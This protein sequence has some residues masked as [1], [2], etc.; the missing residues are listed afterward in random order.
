MDYFSELLESYTKLKKRTFK[1]VYL[2]E[3]EEAQADEER[4]QQII[5]QILAAAA[6]E[7]PSPGTGEPSPGLPKD[8]NGAQEAGSVLTGQTGQTVAVWRKG[9][10]PDGPIIGRLIDGNEVGQL[11]DA[12]G[13][14]ALGRPAGGAVWKALT[15][16][17]VDQVNRT[18]TTELVQKQQGE[19]GYLFTSPE[20]GFPNAG[21]LT[22]LL[23]DNLLALE[24]ICA[25]QRFENPDLSAI[26]GGEEK[27][28]GLIGGNVT[29][30]LE[31][32]LANAFAVSASPKGLV[33]VEPADLA[34][35]IEGALEAHKRLLTVIA[36]NETITPRLC[37]TINQY[38]GRAKN[39]RLVLYV[40]HTGKTRGIAISQT[41]LQKGVLDFLDH[42]GCGVQKHKYA[43][44]KGSL[45]N[46]QGRVNET[47]LG[48]ATAIASE[49]ASLMA[50]GRAWTP[51]PGPGVGTIP[52]EITQILQYYLQDIAADLE[53]IDQLAG[54][55]P[56]S[57]V[58]IS[59][60]SLELA[61]EI[62]E[63]Q[64]EFGTTDGR[65]KYLKLLLAKNFD[66]LSQINADG[67]S[68]IGA[69]QKLGVKSDSIF[70]FKVDP[71]DFDEALGRAS[72]AAAALKLDPSTAP[73]TKTAQ[74]LVDNVRDNKS[75]VVLLR[76]LDRMLG[77]G[78]KGDEEII[79]VNAAQKLSKDP[80]TKQG[81]LSVVRSAQAWIP[82]GQP[83]AFTGKG[84][85][86]TDPTAYWDRLHKFTGLDQTRIANAGSLVSDIHSNL[87]N[88]SRIS[89]K[90]AGPNAASTAAGYNPF[91]DG[92]GH[93]SVMTSQ[94]IATD[95]QALLQMSFPAG[96]MPTLLQNT[97]REY[98]PQGQQQQID[99]S[100]PEARA[101]LSESVQRAYLVTKVRNELDQEPMRDYLITTAGMCIMDME[102]VSQIVAKPNGDTFY[103]D[104]NE[105]LKNMGLA[106]QND[107]SL[108]TISMGA[109]PGK[110]GENVVKFE[111][112]SDPN[113]PTSEKITFRMALERQGDDA[114]WMGR[115]NNEQLKLLEGKE[116]ETHKSN[117]MYE[118]L[119]G[120]HQLLETLLN[121]TT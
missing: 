84:N 99:M 106:Y 44:D 119:K 97:I 39:N 83:G 66:V 56:L 27:Q 67:V 33:R 32:Q 48:T 26:C 108:L 22:S 110:T 58:G 98:T 14:L 101:T 94:Q 102:D 104:Q 9:G 15:G 85:E 71:N 13:Q 21:E 112:P 18:Q 57:E 17:S 90:G 109:E 107:P 86:P 61:D 89:A 29:R 115:T 30:G 82:I 116:I 65:K 79:I 59:T 50:Q 80:S 10:A 42:Q 25:L 43:G 105:L 69:S 78:W 35:D 100:D 19:L 45:E 62:V 120:Q 53:E 74:E 7:L 87:T 1:L 73:I 51:T 64:K 37:K 54:Q 121:Q 60:D 40:P 5:Q 52:P 41:Q 72:G 3:Q 20:K 47:T 81:Q 95:V 76:R 24:N 6:K 77:A 103:Y 55:F 34:G 36:E 31:S 88:A 46:L 23:R 28:S 12:G 8:A 117:L 4:N 70:M 49:I 16:G 68:P 91:W 11:L 111:F 75:R 93:P 113:D 63:F 38:V 92:Q 96:E 118:Y 2:S 114:N